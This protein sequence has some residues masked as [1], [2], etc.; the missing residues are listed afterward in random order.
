[1]LGVVTEQE[2]EVMTVGG[3][4]LVMVM[5][6]SSC[7]DSGSS[8]QAHLWPEHSLLD[9]DN[10]KRSAKLGLPV[11]P[12]CVYRGSRRLWSHAQRSTP[13]PISV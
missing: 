10:R 13:E 7:W 9:P 12:N 3:S 11:A 5:A 4:F 6:V 1:M 8:V 2:Q